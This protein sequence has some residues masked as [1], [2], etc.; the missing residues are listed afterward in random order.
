MVDIFPY[1]GNITAKMFGG[2]SKRV[3]E[4][5]AQEGCFCAGFG[6][7]CCN[8]Y[9]NCSIELCMYVDNTKFDLTP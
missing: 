2:G 6:F 7:F 9:V 3:C 5:W 8:S 1:D 4:G